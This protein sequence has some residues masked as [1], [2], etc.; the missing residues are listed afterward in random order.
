[1]RVKDIFTESTFIRSITVAVIA[2][3]FGI[4][5]A[6]LSA[7]SVLITPQELEQAKVRMTREPLKS[8]FESLSRG[9]GGNSAPILYLLTGEKRYAEKTRAS[10]Q[11]NLDYLRTYI[12]TMINIWILRSP[13][14][15]VSTLLAYDMTKESGVYTADDLR[16]IKETMAWCI[17][18][19]RN[20]GAD[21]LGKGFIYQTDY[22]PEDM[23]DWVIANMNVHRLLAVGLYGLVFPDAPGAAENTRYTVDYFERILS[24]GSRPGGAWAENPRYMGGVLQELYM[25]AAAL[26]N[27]GERDFFQDG[28]F[29]EMLGFFAE[30]I[31]APGMKGP[32]RPTML[33][34]DDSNWWE[35]RGAI[36]AWAAPRYHDGDPD[37]TG[38]WMWCWR[39]LDSPLTPESLLF[40]DPG[41]ASVKPAYT[42][43]LPG[44][45]YVIFR[46]RFAEPDE[47]FLFATFGP[48][49]GTSNRTMHHQPNHGDFS[50]IW[51]GYPVMLTRGCSSYVWS[52]RMRDQTDFSHS[53]VTFDGDGE[54]IVIPEHKYGGP[55]VEVNGGIDESLVRDYYPDGLTNF[56]SAHGFDYAAGEVKNW[57]VG[58][59]APF[60][61]RHLLFL[62]PD[63]LVVWDQVRSSYPLQ[64]NL[65]LPAETVT[66]SGNR[67]SLTNRD[68]VDMTIDFLQDEPL[69][70]TLGWP[71]ESIRA[72]WPMVL[73]CPYGKGMFVFNALDI[74]RQVLYSD[75]EGARKI[76]ENI[77]SYPK[78]PEHIGLIETDGQT[79]AVL[80]RL[81]FSFELLDY[82]ALDGDLS[83]F[84]R[85]V[86]GQFAVLVRDRD[87]ID[88]R[89]KLW[90]YVENGGVCY[91][92]YQYA[93]G[94]KPGD[95]SGPG[96][97]PRTLMV[98]EGTSVL[99]GEGI[100]LWRPVT[101]DDSPIWNSPNRITPAD[102]DGWQVGPP[103]TTKVM[104]LYPILPNTDRARNIPVYYSDY[105]KVHA[106]ALRTYNI[107]VPPTRSRFG[108][109][110]WIKVHHA[111]SDDYFAVLRLGK[112]G[113]TGSPPSDE[114][115]RGTEREALITQGNDVWWIFLGN[116]SGLTGNLAL[117][118]YDA[119]A[120]KFTV[121]KDGEK[122]IDSGQRFTVTPGDI[123]LVDAVD[124]TVG[125][126][127]FLFEHP[128]TLSFGFGTSS[129]K[130]SML[131]GGRIELPWKLT[132]AAISGKSIKVEKTRAGT[133]IAIPPGEY[134]VKIDG[135]SLE[136][137]L[138]S[139]VGRVTVMDGDNRPVQWVHVF[140]DLPGAGRTLFQGATDAQGSLP[141]RW[142]GDERQTITLVKDTKSVRAEIRPGVQTVEFK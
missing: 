114:I 7:S 117:F 109:Y 139:H 81:G 2:L 68:G 9:D 128:A 43:Y 93:W 78:R 30:S 26:K 120:V 11:E 18:H 38:R 123:L 57:D 102:W 23:E 50:L 29:K 66:S 14:Q 73:S 71:L 129:G 40:A 100:E 80:R 122:D 6:T 85:I 142:E 63:V 35:N 90:K 135:N 54:S 118:R 60:N 13:G 8:Y 132:R 97:F 141:V 84:D 111:P 131:E 130:L 82:R 19:Y 34:A 1:M 83:R 94:W 107:N 31:P 36:L 103:D 89:E 101:M 134:A 91:W 92:A 37:E 25:L 112:K 20:H 87:M 79:E 110:R 5:N 86:V 125:G 105:W 39:N 76:L 28:R 3:I 56:V 126:L 27:A 58:L 12:P 59:P 138:I 136:L 65:H 88:W 67:I 99:W 53:V 10:I 75:N 115:L 95:T 44:L 47:T 33:A 45:G 104:P 116:H 52:R 62:K 17:T 48:E 140:R 77:L 113:V 70:F 32:D 15:V 49:Y 64:W 98:G 127:R 74:A 22:I 96:Y 16:E 124:A 24:L 41:I 61:V 4:M 42:S 137:T 69:D 21:H 121:A 106:S 133:V 119:G 72:E 46:D 51:R 108:P 55:A